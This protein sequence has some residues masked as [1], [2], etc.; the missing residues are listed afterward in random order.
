[1]VF[2]EPAIKSKSII[3]LSGGSQDAS[4]VISIR[5]SGHRDQSAPL[6]CQLLC[7]AYATHH[8]SPGFHI[9]TAV[10]LN[11]VAIYIYMRFRRAFNQSYPAFVE[12]STKVV[13]L[14]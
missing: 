12:L 4:L 5:G 13:L 2:V 6:G 7:L 8:T 11:F 3:I 10:I 14:S 1:M 9:R